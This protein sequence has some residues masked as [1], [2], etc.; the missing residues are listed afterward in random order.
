MTDFP[1]GVKIFDVLPKR[2]A[3]DAESETS[4]YW[5]TSEIRGIHGSFKR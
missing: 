3:K 4:A 5:N 2:P 1:Y